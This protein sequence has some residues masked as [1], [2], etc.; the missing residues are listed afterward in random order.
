MNKIIRQIGTTFSHIPP[1]VST[2]VL[3]DQMKLHDFDQR[4]RVID[5]SWDL[6]SAARNTY[7]EHMEK[8]IPGSRFFCIDECSDKQSSL[9]HMLPSTNNFQQYMT[10][11]GVSNHHHVI[12]YDNSPKFGLFSAP[13]V[14]WMLRVFGHEIVSVLDGGLPKW[15]S[16]GFATESG[17]YNTSI[18]T[19]ERSSK[20][21]FPFCTLLS[22]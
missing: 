12:I 10:L 1:L 18:K 16:D 20:H 17:E 15:I 3:N 9:P 2:H 13:R 7:L 4:F 8:R 21:Q 11:L 22:L 5:A 6:P 19:G 14:W